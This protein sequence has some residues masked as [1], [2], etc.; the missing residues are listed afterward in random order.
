MSY[1]THGGINVHA[2][3][4]TEI[5]LKQMPNYYGQYSAMYRATLLIYYTRST[6]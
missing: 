5:D 3:V 2:L 6:N 4:K 1:F